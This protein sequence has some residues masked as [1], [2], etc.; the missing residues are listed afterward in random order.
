MADSFDQGEMEMMRKRV[1]PIVLAVVA[2]GAG[3]GFAWAQAHDEKKGQ[4]GGGAAHWD[5]KGAAGWGKNEE[6]FKTCA[7]G[8][9]QT[10]INITAAVVNATSATPLTIT[11]PRGLKGTFQNNG[12]TVQVDYI[13]RKETDKWPKEMS[14]FTLKT[15]DGLYDLKQFHFHTPSENKFEDV[16]FAMEAHFVHYD[17]TGNAAVLAVMFKQSEKDNAE[18]ETLWKNLPPSKDN[19]KGDVTFNPADLLPASTAR[20]YFSFEGSLTT[21]PCSEVVRWYVL[22]TPIGVSKAQVDRLKAKL[23]ELNARPVQN[24]NARTI[25]QYQ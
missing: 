14:G 6:A 13:G 15:E 17:N 23:P 5:Y 2:L 24:V 1:T 10:P 21:P 4:A 19:R 7:F 20:G 11:Y 8:T 22:K 3:H 18:L 16:P 12:H 25:R 9:K